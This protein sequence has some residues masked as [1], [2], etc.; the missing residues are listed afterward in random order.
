MVVQARG[1]PG[2]VND[3]IGESE[4]GMLKETIRKGV[5]LFLAAVAA[6]GL[7]E[8]LRKPARQRTWHGRIIGIPYD[9]RPPTLARLRETLWNPDDPHIIT[10]RALGVGWSINF[11][12]LAHPGAGAK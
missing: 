11:Y 3:A 10:P 7:V 2:A 12:R 8:Q 4:V 6:A 5:T 9:Y 1:D